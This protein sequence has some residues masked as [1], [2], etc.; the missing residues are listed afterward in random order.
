MSSGVEIIEWHVEALGYWLLAGH[1][2]ALLRVVDLV[3]LLGVARSA[4]SSARKAHWPA[5]V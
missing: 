5:T 2:F 4:K 3:E 1:R